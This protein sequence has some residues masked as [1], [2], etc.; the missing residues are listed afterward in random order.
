MVKRKNI[1]VCVLLS[2][3]TLGIYVL[4][5]MASIANSINELDNNGDKNVKGVMVVLFNFLTCG[6]YGLYW[7][8]KTGERV[9]KL[10]N[11]NGIP[12]QNNTA[13][14]YMFLDAFVVA[15]TTIC[16]RVPDHSYIWTGVGSVCAI[17]GSIVVFCL[18]QNDI[19]QLVELD[20]N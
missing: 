1:A 14:K 17:A 15:I 8:Y 9:D 6:A 18:M 13:I 10:K 5:W 19:N 20:K 12:T 7:D 16:S 4:F 2:I 11:A 3:L